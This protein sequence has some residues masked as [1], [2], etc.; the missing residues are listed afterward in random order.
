MVGVSDDICCVLVSK[1][2]YQFCG[3]LNAKSNGRWQYLIFRGLT[4]VKAE[5]V[6]RKPISARVENVS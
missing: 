5:D 2:K 4:E 1:T 3:A 6:K